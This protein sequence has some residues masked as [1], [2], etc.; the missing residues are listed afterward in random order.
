[1]H[2]STE[3][4]PQVFLKVDEEFNQTLEVFQFFGATDSNIYSFYDW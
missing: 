3:S 2:L 1:M 4:F